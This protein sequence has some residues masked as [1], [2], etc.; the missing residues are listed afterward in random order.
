MERTGT[1]EQKN[2]TR[3]DALK[4]F[5]DCEFRFSQYLQLQLKSCFEYKML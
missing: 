4:G 2:G 5:L 3:R 1:E